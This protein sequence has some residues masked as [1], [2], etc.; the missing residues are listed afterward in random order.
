[1]KYLKY[2][3]NDASY[4][5]RLK[6]SSVAEA[7]SELLKIMGVGR[8]VSA[9]SLT[10]ASRASR[11]EQVADCVL[12]MSLGKQDV[13][14]VDTHIHSI[15]TTHYGQKKQ[16]SLS[17]SNYDAISTFFEQLW[18]PY[19]GWAQAVSVSRRV[20]SIFTLS[21]CFLQAAFSNE[22][23]WPTSGALKRSKSSADANPRRKSSK[24]EIIKE[25]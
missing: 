2:T 14:P 15:A 17:T 21:L 6:S 8:K 3:V 9:F 12:L 25:C 7:R 10:S 11:S 24:R 5:D 4:F 18:K 1:M 23:R 13:V 16:A 20:R 22:L 19:A